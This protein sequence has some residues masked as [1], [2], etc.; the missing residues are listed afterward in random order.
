MPSCGILWQN[1][2]VHCISDPTISW[3][4]VSF[5]GKALCCRFWGQRW[6]YLIAQH[7]MPSYC[8]IWQSIALH[9]DSTISC[10]PKACYGKHCIALHKWSHNIIALHSLGFRWGSWHW[11]TYQ[12]YAMIWVWKGILIA[13]PIGCFHRPMEA[14]DSIPMTW[15]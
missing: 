1:I 7:I 3:F 14:P 2:L 13:C 12:W 11:H 5:C 8:M 15:L 6:Q 4:P 10:H 9:S